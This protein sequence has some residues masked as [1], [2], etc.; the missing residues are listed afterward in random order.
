VHVYDQYYSKPFDTPAEDAPT[1]YYMDLQPVGWGVETW[2][3]GSPRPGIKCVHRP[4]HGLANALRKAS[5]VP[6]VAAA[7]R[8]KQGKRFDFSTDMVNTMQAA[9]LFE[10]CLRK[11]DIGFNDDPEIVEA[12][13]VIK[14]NAFMEYHSAACAAF[15]DYAA[16]HSFDKASAAIC[17]EALSCMYM[18]P[19]SDA[20]A[21]AKAIL[22]AC[23]DLD[24]F[25]CYGGSRM[26]N[27]IKHLKSK[28]GE[29]AGERLAKLAVQMIRK[30]GDRLLFSP[31]D[32]LPTG[33]YSLALFSKCSHDSQECL[34][35]IS[36]GAPTI[37]VKKTL[38]PGPFVEGEAQAGRFIGSRYK[39]LYEAQKHKWDAIKW[40]ATTINDQKKEIRE[41]VRSLLKEYCKYKGLGE[42]ADWWD[43]ADNFFQGM[44]GD[45][46]EE[47]SVWMW[48]SDHQDKA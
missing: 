36:G 34:D 39:L 27:K 41:A 40:D 26:V 29:A 20:S 14:R 18:H 44:T 13:V 43:Y 17:V 7:F 31:F 38:Q 47:L 15:K 32:D 22:E 19:K 4:N 37:K 12:G 1:A 24:L 25:R 16:T 28:V 48:S 11:S 45:N 9:M 21:P 10:V 30:T 2:P 6:E 42:D 5:L 3:A 46:T 33:F 35:A 8:E 23:H